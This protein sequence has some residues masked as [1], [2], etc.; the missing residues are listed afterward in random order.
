MLYSFL[1]GIRYTDIGG[2]DDDDDDDDETSSRCILLVNSSLLITK[3]VHC[4]GLVSYDDLRW[5]KS[6]NKS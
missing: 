3:Q 6:W 2:D 5:V 4:L 1:K